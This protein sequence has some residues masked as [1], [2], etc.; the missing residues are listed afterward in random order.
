MGRDGVKENKPWARGDP[1]DDKQSG[2]VASKQAGKAPTPNPKLTSPNG[3]AAGKPGGSKSGGQRQSGQKA[4]DKQPASGKQNEHSDRAAQSRNPQQRQQET[5]RKQPGADNKSPPAEKSP[6]ADQ[7]QSDKQSQSNDNSQSGEKSQAGE[8]SKDAGRSQTEQDKRQQASGGSS[9]ASS[10]PPEQKPADKG[11]DKAK[12]QSQGSK[13]AGGAPPRSIVPH[14][15][16][17][18]F[19]PLS[20]LGIFKWLIYLAI[21]IFIVYA[22]CSNRDRLLAALSDFGQ[23]W[24]DFLARLFGGRRSA[25]SDAAADEA[26]PRSAPLPRFVDYADPFAAGVAARYPPEELVRYTFEALEAWGRDHGCPRAAEQTPHEFTRHL[27]A[28]ASALADD[29][30]RLADLYCQAAYADARLSAA[31]VKRLSR[32]WQI[33]QAETV[34]ST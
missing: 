33:M 6:S 19:S 34:W 5:G 18:S 31:S 27:A 10:K 1:K 26:G 24:Q 17:V 21:A 8:Q 29:A 7:S 9:A 16:N 4:A 22:V 14:L 30:R 32:L 20:L 15:P 23:W 25:R 28:N 3:K 12:Q 11:D 13:G 2:S